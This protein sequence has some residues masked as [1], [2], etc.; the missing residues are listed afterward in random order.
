MTIPR[1]QLL[2][3]SLSAAAMTTV[4][5]RATS[6]ATEETPFA[7]KYILASC[8]YGYTDIATILPEASKIGATAIDIW[9]MVHGNQREQLDQIGE[10]KFSGLLKRYEVS[11]GCISQYKLGP[12]K[13]ENEMRLAQRLG[14]GMIVTNAVGPTKLSGSAL[15]QAISQFIE[16]MKPHVA[17]AEETGVTI[18]IENHHN[19]L[20]DSPDSMKY[21][22]DLV[23]SRHLSLGFAPYHLPQQEKLLEQLIVDLGNR[24][25]IFYAWEHGNGC[26]AKLP[27]SEELLQMP[28]RGKLDFEP[29]LAALK[30]IRF[31]GWT[32]I[33]MH[34]FPRGISIMESTQEVTQE[35]NRARDYL[36]SVLA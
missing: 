27:K 4:F 30:R 23:P 17:L 31:E 24:I 13:L 9:P 5:A 33:F 16:T 28:G 11:L 12:L 10:E 19:N 20:I 29:L 18:A 1:R 15:K 7:L 2:Q 21:F 34:P 3:G 8:M 36:E 14:C 6:A 22:A 25:S 26:M 32:E 35:I